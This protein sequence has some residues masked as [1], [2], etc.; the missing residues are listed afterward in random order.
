MFREDPEEI[1]VQARL[2]GE[3]PGYS[4]TSSRDFR[5]RTDRAKQA[6]FVFRE[7]PE[8]TRGQ[9]RLFGYSPGD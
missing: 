7:D 3:S 9:A 5:V 1:R 6:Q 4:G 8:V 2:L